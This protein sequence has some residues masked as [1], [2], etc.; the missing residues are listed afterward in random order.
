[1][2]NDDSKL[3]RPTHPTPLWD[4]IQRQEEAKS[5]NLDLY[6]G[7]WRTA[8]TLAHNICVQDSD[9]INADDGPPEAMDA[10][11][12]ASRRIRG[13][14]E[15]TDQQLIEML[16]EAGALQDETAA[17]HREGTYLTRTFWSPDKRYLVT[18]HF[19]HGDI[20]TLQD[21]NGRE[22]EAT[23]TTIRMEDVPR[24]AVKTPVAH[25]IEGN[26]FLRTKEKP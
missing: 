6:R 8:L 5:S 26:L 23:G 21:D 25:E 7:A 2:S 17:P 10:L 3:M 18:A 1:M 15:P 22:W 14:I 24:P 19:T 4:S 9:R 11:S 16:R 20:V 12:E 13:W